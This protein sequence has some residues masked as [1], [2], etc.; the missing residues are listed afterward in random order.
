MN[1]NNLGPCLTAGGR[2]F[3]A[4]SLSVF[5]FTVALF[6]CL[7]VGKAQA[8]SFSLSSGGD[9]Q[10]AQGSSVSN[11]ITATVTST[12]GGVQNVGFSLTGLPS[13]S[14]YSFSPT[15]CLPTCSTTLI[16]NTTTATPQGN[17]AIKVYAA[18]SA[19][20]APVRSTTFT[21][22]VGI[23]SAT[24][25]PTPTPI[26]STKFLINDRVQ[27]NFG[28][29]NVRSTPSTSGT[30]LG[31][32]VTGQLG[33]VIG[34]PTNSGG[35]NWWNINY[36]S[37]A[38]GWSAEN[39]LTKVASPTPTPTPT[40]TTSSGPIAWYKLDGNASD[41]SGLG[42]NGTLVN[43]PT[44]TT[45][46]LGQALSFDGVDDNVSLGNTSALQITGNQT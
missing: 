9:K 38:D 31:T 16:I 34:G 42:N 24:P 1:K 39:Y 30:I 41:S 21:L 8:F 13:N 10:V 12:T 14:T 6:T 11:V 7:P 45:G 44:F 5:I 19:R 18:S 35:F 2:A 36:D 46:Q 17:Y 20:G 37:G 40:P 22:S 33:T 3:I 23:S 29:L 4:V 25:T 32:Q 43:G 28:P 26:V 27:V 15:A